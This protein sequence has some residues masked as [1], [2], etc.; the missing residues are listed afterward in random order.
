MLQIKI[1][2]L[3]ELVFTAL[4]LIPIEFNEQERFYINHQ[5]ELFVRCSS[6]TCRALPYF[7]LSI[8]CLHQRKTERR[9]VFVDYTRRSSEME[10][11]GKYTDLCVKCT[12]FFSE[13]SLCKA[14]AYYKSEKAQRNISTVNV[15]WCRT[16]VM[17]ENKT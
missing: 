12:F 13:K 16:V 9:S 14:N 7:R 17:P 15:K 3:Y 1:D 6:R 5:Q 10:I 4:T 8:C 11:I 2:R